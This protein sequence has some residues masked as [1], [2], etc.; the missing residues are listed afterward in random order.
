M[1]NIVSSDMIFDILTLVR[2]DGWTSS[3]SV[4]GFSGYVKWMG[5]NP[6]LPNIPFNHPSIVSNSIYVSN[7]L[8]CQIL[9]YKYI[10]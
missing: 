6:V 7:K 8:I 5:F 1:K 2:R 4:I 10:F 3:P 9:L